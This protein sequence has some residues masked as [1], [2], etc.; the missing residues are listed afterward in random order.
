MIW[1]F[2]VQIAKGYQV[3]HDANLLHRDIKP[4]NI[5]IHNKIFKLADFGLAKHIKDYTIKENQSYAGTPL[6][7]APDIT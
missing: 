6:Y 5:L 4:D 7:I 1:D 2:I 3:L